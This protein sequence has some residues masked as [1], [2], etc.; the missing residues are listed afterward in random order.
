MTA[1][2]TGAAAVV[3]LGSVASVAREIVKPEAVAGSIFVGLEHI[4]PDGT[5]EGARRAEV[6]DVASAK[7]RFGPQDLLFGKLRPNLRKVARPDSEGVCSTDILP[8]RPGPKV[9]R[10]YLF[11]WLRSPGVTRLAT[12]RTSGANLPRLSPVELLRF[13]I[14]LP[15]IAEQQRIAAIFD[16]ADSIRRKRQQAI[17]LTDDLLRSAFLDMFGDPVT[18][19][20]EWPTDTFAT[21]LAGVEAGW[22]VKGD[23]RP[24]ADGEWAVLR[25]S[26]VTS[27]RF[28]PS[29]HKVVSEP[30]GKKRPILP[31]RG[32]LLFSRANTRELVGAVALVERDVDHLFLP[33]KLWRLLPN[34]K[35]AL[36]EYLRLVLGHPGYQRSLAAHA[37]G[38]SGSMLNVSQVKLLQM[39]LPLPPVSHQE[40]FA[41]LVWSIYRTQEKINCLGGELASLFESFAQHA[42]HGEL[43][44]PRVTQVRETAPGPDNE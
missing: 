37:T 12:Q 17:Q 32:D 38:T 8:I 28:D 40:H 42:F 11:H 23:D 10:A 25:I 18:N 44:S 6:G 26:A 19:P 30:L 9:D 27:G 2:T 7:F 4:M 34:R 20:R 15:P 39:K 41:A 36:P 22:S 16:Q 29:Q 5:I 24:R 1:V 13:R 3:P 43:T 35:V 31:T 14:P 21:A 33:D